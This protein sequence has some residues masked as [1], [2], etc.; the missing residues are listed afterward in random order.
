MNSSR[1]LHHICMV[2]V[3]PPPVHGQSLVHE[4]V[5]KRLLA[6]NVQPFVINISPSSLDRSLSVRLSR[7]KKVIGSIGLYARTLLFKECRSLYIGVSGG[8]GQLYEVAFVAL[9]RLFRRQIFLHHNTYSYVTKRK[10]VAWLL[11]RVSGPKAV[12]IVLCEDMAFRLK[13][14]YKS[15]HRVVV[16]SN[17]VHITANQ[18]ATDKSKDSLRAI[19]FLSNISLDKGILE[20]LDVLGCLENEGLTLRGFIAGPFQ[21]KE[22]EAT[23]MKRLSRLKTARYVGPKYDQEKDSFFDAIDVLLFPTRYEAEA[24]PL[25][26]Y[27]A[28][29][30]GVP[31]IAWERGCIANILTLDVGMVVRRR[32]NFARRCVDQL[33]LWHA[34]PSSFRQTS[35]A[36]VDRYL[37]MRSKF[38]KTLEELLSLMMGSF[39]GSCGS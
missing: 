17:V 7:I 37:A 15:V 10:L 35:S 3:F 23:V 12:H 28:M 13:V 11:T 20:F 21:D 27:E 33:S 24:D 25:T 8:Y 5:R 31:V 39:S 19:G 32:D 34:S 36:A 6:L 1:V 16:L 22:I 18:C 14:L 29:S 38:Q 26:I 2:G 9:A 4:A 30:C